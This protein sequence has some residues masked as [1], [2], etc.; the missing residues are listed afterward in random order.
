MAESRFSFTQLVSLSIAMSLFFAFDQAMGF[1]ARIAFRL[2][3]DADMYGVFAFLINIFVFFAGLNGFSMNV[4]IIARI[5]ENPQD[6]TFYRS[7]SSQILSA[8]I[9]FGSVLSTV[10]FLWTLPVTSELVVVLF[11]A[12]MILLYSTGQIIHCFPRGR[13]RFR[14]AAVSLLLVG[15]CRVVLLIPFLSGVFTNLLFAMLLYVGPFLGWWASYLFF[16][17]VPSLRYPKPKLLLSVYT[18]SFISYLYP[19]GMQIPVV[20]G[21]IFLTGFH[22]FHTAGDFD[23]AL[24][25]YFALAALFTG[26]SFVTI[27]KARKLP[28]FR[29]LLK[30]MKVSA[31][32]PLFALSMVFIVAAFFLESAVGPILTLLGLPFAVYWPVVLLV[33]IGVPFRLVISVFVSYFQGH[34]AIKPVGVIIGI[35]SIGSI[36]LQ[37]I[38]AYYLSIEGVIL[39]MVLINAAIVLLLL[40]YG[41][42]KSENFQGFEETNF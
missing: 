3:L 13:E 24:I 9:V 5:S 22:G 32:L 25:P 20:L 19:L 2:T 10:F 16:E 38:L 29:S 33:A 26:I 41:H 30:T 11:L 1:I 8:S 42:R 39:S 34:G 36:P 31:F 37:I 23:I 18:D 28:S 14:P 17:G 15:I 27:S 12:V 4:P 35:C 6:D 7:F 40:G 21:V